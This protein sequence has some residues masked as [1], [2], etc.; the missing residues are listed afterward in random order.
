MDRPSI[1]AMTLPN[2]TNVGSNYMVCET[3]ET[4]PRALVVMANRAVS[5]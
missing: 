5:R 2:E 3:N 4:K 1:L